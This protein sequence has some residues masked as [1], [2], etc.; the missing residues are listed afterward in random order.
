[1]LKLDRRERDGVDPFL[2]PRFPGLEG[3]QGFQ[4]SPHVPDSLVETLSHRELDVCI[5]SES[6]DLV[7]EAATRLIGDRLRALAERSTRPDLVIVALPTELEE[8]ASSPRHRRRARVPDLIIPAHPQ[9]F[10]FG[11]DTRRPSDEPPL[12]RTLHRALK[13]EAM[14]AGVQLP[15]Q[16]AWPRTFNGGDDVQD[17]ATRAWNF[18]VA[19]YYKA[20]GCPWQISTLRADTCYVGI[21]FYRPMGDIGSL[22]TSM[23]QVFSHRGDGMVLRG[24]TFNWNSRRM[25]E[26]HVPRDHARDLLRDVLVQY[27]THMQM[28]PVRLVIHKTSS[29]SKDEI[30][31]F[32]DALDN[33]RFRDFVSIDGGSRLRFLRQGEEPPLRGTVIEV[34]PRTHA[35]FTSGYVPFLQVYPGFR[36]PV[37]LIVRHDHGD[38]SPTMVMTEILGLTKLNWNSASFATREPITLDFAR[39]VGRILSELPNGIQPATS[40]RFYM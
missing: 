15:I 4:C 1:V 2:F 3:S 8:F 7:V 18:W 39:D 27:R 21:S 29:F 16:I 23:A 13:A 19:S 34:A 31:G 35:L 20:G 40:Y 6:R 38:D 10:L 28:D 33:I 17:D 14:R 9:L 30:A 37:P 24:Q 22:Q 11:D 36:V 5:R 32:E 26:P 12:A 25:G